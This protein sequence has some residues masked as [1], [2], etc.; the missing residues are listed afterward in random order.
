MKKCSEIAYMKLNS[1]LSNFVSV[2]SIAT[3]LV[4]ELFN[5]IKIN[6]S[7]KINKYFITYIR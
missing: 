2:I 5:L 4:T 1:S 7:N 3:G 6:I